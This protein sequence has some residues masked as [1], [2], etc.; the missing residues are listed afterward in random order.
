MEGLV[1]LTDRHP[2]KGYEKAAILLGEL[3]PQASGPVLK[4]LKLTP[5]QSRRIRKNIKK[6]GR[7][8][9]DDFKQVSKELSVL[10]ETINYGKAKGI[11]NS[12][13]AIQNSFV[14]KTETSVKQMAS[15]DPDSIANVIK[16]WLNN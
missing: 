12:A 9:P 14:R 1:K 3:G 11:Y 2:I 6:L 15:D 7:Y 5:R 4:A 8:N 10:T 13:K 16:M